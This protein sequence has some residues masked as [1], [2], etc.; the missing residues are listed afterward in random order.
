MDYTKTK[1]DASN[2]KL[3]LGARLQEIADEKTRL[4][5]EAE[6]IKRELIG[7]D[8]ILDGVEF[9]TSD[10]PTDFEPPGFTDKIRKILSETPVPLVPTQVRDALQAAG[11]T[12]SSAKNLLINVHTVLE[13]IE[14]ELDKTTTPEGKTAYKRKVPWPSY[15]SVWSTALEEILKPR[16]ATNPALAP[17]TPVLPSSRYRRRTFGQK[18][19]G[20][21]GDPPVTDKT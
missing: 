13:R 6:Q 11:V 2:R 19:A 12:G 9:M 4:D 3:E 1:Q 20:K 17:G 14:S 5:G 15:S 8:Q 21:F 18:V 10:M 7:L 16:P